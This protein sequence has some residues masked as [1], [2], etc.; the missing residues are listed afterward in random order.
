[1]PERVRWEKD[2]TVEH[3]N[4]ETVSRTSPRNDQHAISTAEVEQPSKK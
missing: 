4:G 3:G 2:T 1:M